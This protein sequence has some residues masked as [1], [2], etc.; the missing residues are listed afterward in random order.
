MLTAPV[1]VVIAKDG[2]I[3]VGTD[4]TVVNEVEVL[5]K[6]GSLLPSTGGRGTTILYVLGAL[7]VLG[8][9][10]VLITKRRMKE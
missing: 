4:A 5:N 8:S 2:A 9:S 3:T 7:L 1:T 10:V 6:T